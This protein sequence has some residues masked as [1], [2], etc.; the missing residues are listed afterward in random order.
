MIIRR[1]DLEDLDALVANRME[2]LDLVRTD[3]STAADDGLAAVTH[4]FMKEHL[5]DETLVVW[6]AEEEGK[7]VSTAMVCYY[8]QLPNN[9]NTTGRMGYIQNVYTLAD[10]RRRG[11]ASELLNR[12]IRDAGERKAGRLMLDATDMGQPVY[13]KLGFILMKH[14]MSYKLA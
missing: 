10:Y 13:E 8:R 9:S 12:I 14:E 11:L 1:G 2:F 7:I 6:L 3:P 4:A 5:Q